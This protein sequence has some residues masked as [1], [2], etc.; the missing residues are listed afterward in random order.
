DDLLLGADQR[1]AAPTRDHHLGHGV[2]A[3][4]RI[5]ALV[6]LG[7]HGVDDVARGGPVA[8][9][10]HVIMIE[11]FGFLLGLG[12]HH[13]GVAPHFHLAAVGL[14]RQRVISGDVRGIGGDVVAADIGEDEI[15]VP[16]GKVAAALR[17]TGVHD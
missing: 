10:V 16:A 14:A 13:V 2:A 5:V 3:F 4:L 1:E 6:D 15:A 12:L 9:L 17:R 11:V 7:R 8:L